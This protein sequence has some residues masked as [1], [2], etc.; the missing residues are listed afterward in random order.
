MSRS[1]ETSSSRHTLPHAYASQCESF[2]GWLGQGGTA[3]SLMV[4]PQPE[5]LAEAEVG[6]P[7]VRRAD[8]KPRSRARSRTRKAAQ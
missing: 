6:Q 5:V 4:P 3:Q 8:Q 7:A 2:A 1:G